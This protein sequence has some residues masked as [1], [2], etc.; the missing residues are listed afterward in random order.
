MQDIYLL[1]LYRP[2]A[3]LTVPFIPLLRGLEKTGSKVINIF[4]SITVL[5]IVLTS[6]NLVM[7]G[8][9]RLLQVLWSDIDNALPLPF[10]LQTKWYLFTLAMIIIILWLIIIKKSDSYS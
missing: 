7:D 3:L 5:I 1:P 8:E 2:L 4:F 10:A 9:A 6:F